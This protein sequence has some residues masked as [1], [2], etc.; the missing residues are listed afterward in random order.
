MPGSELGSSID[1]DSPAASPG[2]VTPRRTSRSFFALRVVAACVGFVAVWVGAFWIGAVKAGLRKAGY[3]GVEVF[4]T[5][6]PAST[7]WIMI[8]VT[9]IGVVLM[10]GVAQ[11]RVDGVQLFGSIWF[12]F[13]T[14]WFLLVTSRLEFFADPDTPC[15]NEGCW[16]QGYQ[17]LLIAVPVIGTCIAMIIMSFLQKVRWIWRALIPASV[18]VVLAVLQRLT[19]EEYVLPL[20]VAP[21]S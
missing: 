15:R 16:P 6:T 3:V 11:R 4:P 9:A 18:F 19:W 5:T 8:V 20:L 10:T 12:S 2:G 14:G 17:E 21:P 13:W 7:A 1:E